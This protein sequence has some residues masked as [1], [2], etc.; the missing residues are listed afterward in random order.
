MATSGFVYLGQQLSIQ[1]DEANDSTTFSY[2]QSGEMREGLQLPSPIR[3]V[4]LLL[5]VIFDVLLLA[6]LDSNAKLSCSLAT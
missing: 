6:S 5:G 4:I 1:K 2:R 3:T